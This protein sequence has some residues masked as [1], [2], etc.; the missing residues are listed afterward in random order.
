[1]LIQDMIQRDGQF[2]VWHVLGKNGRFHRLS[3]LSPSLHGPATQAAESCTDQDDND[4]F[5]TPS[6]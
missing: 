4:V 3:I 6:C 2:E 5:G 1:M